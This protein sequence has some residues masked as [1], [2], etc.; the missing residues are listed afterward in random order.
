MN[1]YHAADLFPSFF[2]HDNVHV[3]CKSVVNCVCVKE[4]GENKGVLPWQ[5]LALLVKL[6]KFTMLILALKLMYT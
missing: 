3:S 5:R 1:F 2:Q 4:G 6:H